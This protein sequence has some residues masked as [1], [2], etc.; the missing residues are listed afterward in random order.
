MHV[1]RGLLQALGLDR[2]RRV[3]VDLCATPPPDHSDLT[4]PK[5]ADP[6]GHPRRAPSLPTHAH[7]KSERH[8]DNPQYDGSPLFVDDSC[9][10]SYEAQTASNHQSDT[11]PL[12][13]G[14]RVNRR[15]IRLCVTHV[16]LV[17]IKLPH[18]PPYPPPFGFAGEQRLLWSYWWELALLESEL[19]PLPQSE[20]APV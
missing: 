20:V 17:R 12:P 14:G 5:P 7:R 6:T 8:D 15:A 18:H 10:Q 13:C 4:Q 2:P 9:N 19:L 3:H 16:L 1:A 11:R